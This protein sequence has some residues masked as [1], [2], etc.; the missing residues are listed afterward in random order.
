MSL[1]N[2][3]ERA[4]MRVVMELVNL[5]RAVKAA[6]AEVDPPAAHLLREI[7]ERVTTMSD[8]FTSELALLRDDVAA[9]KTV[10]LSATTAFT[11][12]AAAL[13]AAENKA[14]A[15]GATPEQLAGITSVRTGLE[16]NTAD[17][18][19][20]IP[21]NVPAAPGSSS[22]SQTQA[23]APGSVVTESGNM[24]QPQALPDTA[25]QPT[26]PVPVLTP[27]DPT[28]APIVQTAPDVPGAP[29]TV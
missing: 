5:C 19:A 29:L 13:L 14:V 27:A 7:L 12:L 26:S 8:T 15:A 1:F 16:S 18:A 4:A 25:A 28:A 17:L 24:V 20:A 23:P 11:G 21:Q 3:A 22:S 10:I 6:S 2:E 9:Q